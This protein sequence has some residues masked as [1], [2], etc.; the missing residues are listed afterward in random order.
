M[1]LAALDV[2]LGR[3]I[4][5]SF[6]LFLS[7]VFVL[8]TIG[9]IVNAFG[10]ETF[11]DQLAAVVHSLSAASISW[12]ARHF[13]RNLDPTRSPELVEEGSRPFG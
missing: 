12:S 7:L 9:I 8:V 13:L 10:L 11:D 5:Q 2:Y 3:V 4:L 6:Y 1:A